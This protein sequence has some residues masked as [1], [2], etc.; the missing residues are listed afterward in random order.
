MKKY[1]WLFLLDSWN[2]F[3]KFIIENNEVI[4]M[5]F[6]DKELK[7]IYFKVGNIIYVWVYYFDYFIFGFFILWCNVYLLREFYILCIVLFI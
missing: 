3:K 2:L 6:R 4:E 7:V 5:F 1:L